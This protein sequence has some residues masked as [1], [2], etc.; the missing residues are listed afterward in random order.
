ML[1]APTQQPYVAVVW[2]TGMRRVRCQRSE[3]SPA[4]PTGTPPL[5]ETAELLSN[6]AFSLEILQRDL[7][8]LRPETRQSHHIDGKTPI[9]LG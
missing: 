9:L 7:D 2:Q 6:E 8:F 5:D 1:V 4:R 3:S